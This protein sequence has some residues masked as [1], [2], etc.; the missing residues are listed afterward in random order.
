MHHK[1]YNVCVK[2]HHGHM[3]F[4]ATNTEYNKKYAYR[5]WNVLMVTNDILTLCKKQKMGI[6]LEYCNVDFIRK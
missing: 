3:P 4:G 6:E 2:R 5:K 1:T